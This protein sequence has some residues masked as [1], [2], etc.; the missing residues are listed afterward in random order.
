MQNPDTPPLRPDSTLHLPDD[1]H[2]NLTPNLTA[3]QIERAHNI[4][5]QVL[6]YLRSQSRHL[7]PETGLALTYDAQPEADR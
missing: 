4:L 7:P 5:H 1:L 3:D 2:P 6:T